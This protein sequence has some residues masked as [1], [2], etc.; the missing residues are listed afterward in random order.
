MASLTDVSVILLD[1]IGLRPKNWPLEPT[2]KKTMAV[3]GKLKNVIDAQ[4]KKKNLCSSLTEM[5]L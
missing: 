5:P 2:E 3:V 1:K 4:T